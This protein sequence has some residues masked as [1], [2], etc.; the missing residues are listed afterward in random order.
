MTLKFIDHL[1]GSRTWVVPET[2]PER[3]LTELRKTEARLLRDLSG[4]LTAHFAAAAA[5]HGAAREQDPDYERSR[6]LLVHFCDR[7]R[8]DARDRFTDLHLPG[9]PVCAPCAI[10]HQQPGKED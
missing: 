3:D 6:M 8:E 7:L 4:Q 2:Q 10:V 1:D 9:Q 5:I